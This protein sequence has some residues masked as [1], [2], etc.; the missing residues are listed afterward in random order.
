[1]LYKCKDLLLCVAGGKPAKPWCRQLQNR[2][3]YYSCFLQSTSS[4]W[5]LK[6]TSGDGLCLSWIRSLLVRAGWRWWPVADGGLWSTML[7]GSLSSRDPACEKLAVA[8]SACVSWLHMGRQARHW[9]MIVCQEDSAA[10]LTLPLP[11]RGDILCSLLSCF[12]ALLIPVTSRS[13]SLSTNFFVR[14]CF[15]WFPPKRCISNYFLFSFV[16]GW[17]IIN[18]KV[19]MT[20]PAG[21]W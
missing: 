11:S 5:N 18:N 21:V 7:V 14:L 1:M 2:L 10:G 15:F 16:K 20:F 13:Q 12:P 17:K 9:K 8:S 6:R 4:S 19:Q 3:P